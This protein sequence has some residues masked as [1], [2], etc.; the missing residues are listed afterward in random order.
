MDCGRRFLGPCPPQAPAHAVVYVMHCGCVGLISGLR[1]YYLG[2]N[3]G[4][5]MTR[6]D[7]KARPGDKRQQ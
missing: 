2:A 1:P 4:S 7:E 5:I 3:G 6:P